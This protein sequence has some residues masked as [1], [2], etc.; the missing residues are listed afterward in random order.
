M[1][2]PVVVCLLKGAGQLVTAITICRSFW[3][4]PLRM[5]SESG[6]PSMKAIEIKCLPS[7]SPTS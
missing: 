2:D 4:L 5:R 1:H 3:A 6:R 7:I